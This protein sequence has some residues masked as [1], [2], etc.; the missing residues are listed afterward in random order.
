MGHGA[1]GMGMGHGAWAKRRDGAWEA[2]NNNKYKKN[3]K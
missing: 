3:Q 2:T 1:W